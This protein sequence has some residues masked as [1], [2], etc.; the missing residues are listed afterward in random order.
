MD[1]HALCRAT[2]SGLAAKCFENSGGRTKRQGS[3]ERALLI[4]RYVFSNFVTPPLRKLLR[5][6]ILVS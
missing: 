4:C 5:S 1:M 2:I 3:S 6:R